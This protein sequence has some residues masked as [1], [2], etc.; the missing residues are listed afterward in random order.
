M[1]LTSVTTR[2]IFHFKQQLPTNIL[3]E[4]QTLNIHLSSDSTIVTFGNKELQVH[5]MFP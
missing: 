1:G 4:Q 3:R 5:F 2:L